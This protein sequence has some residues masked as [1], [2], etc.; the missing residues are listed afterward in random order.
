M[1]KS[2]G[3]TGRASS[4]QIKFITR[5]VSELPPAE[6]AIIHLHFWNDYTV[7]EMASFCGLSQTL[8][9]KILDH[10]IHRLRLN[11][12]VEFSIP[13]EMTRSYVA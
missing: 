3:H 6:M 4:E 11:Y 10:A 9:Q 2:F 5:S 1:G 8:T 13:K 12:L 7:K